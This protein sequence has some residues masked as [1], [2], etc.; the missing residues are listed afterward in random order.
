M[1]FL[2]RALIRKSGHAEQVPDDGAVSHAWTRSVC[3][4]DAVQMRL[5]HGVAVILES[6]FASKWPISIWQKVS[7]NVRWT[8]TSGKEGVLYRGVPSVRVLM[9]E[10][11][12]SP[13]RASG[14]LDGPSFQLCAPRTV[15]LWLPGV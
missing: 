12:H 15:H 13:Q 10:W 3:G 6:N 7:F 1:A 4:L 8:E 2:C 14:G 5:E 11:T 9:D